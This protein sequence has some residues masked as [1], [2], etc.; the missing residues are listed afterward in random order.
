[1]NQFIVKIQIKIQKSSLHKRTSEF[2]QLRNYFYQS[3]V[4]NFWTIRLTHGQKNLK[5]IRD[6]EFTED[7]RKNERV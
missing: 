4:K 2:L 3:K 7:N 5:F 6:V 1:M